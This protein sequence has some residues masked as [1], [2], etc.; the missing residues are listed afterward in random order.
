MLILKQLQKKW[1]PAHQTPKNRS[2]KN[3]KN[4]PS[5]FCYYVKCEGEENYPEPVVYRGEDCV[6][7][8]V[9]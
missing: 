2:P 8:F 3:I 5:G 4:T 1:I 6:Q 7:K 9:K